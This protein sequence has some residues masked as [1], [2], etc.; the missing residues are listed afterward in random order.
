MDG[1]D[2]ISPQVNPDGS[3]TLRFYAPRARSVAL[4]AEI[5]SLRGQDCWPLARD[6]DGVWS[7]T[8][9]GIQPDTYSYNFDIEQRLIQPHRGFAPSDQRL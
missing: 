5:T 6:A 7:A 4:T 1:T 2:V 9:R 8:V 3:V